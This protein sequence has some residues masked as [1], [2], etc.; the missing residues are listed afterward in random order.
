MITVKIT[1]Y[2]IEKNKRYK[3][4][5]LIEKDYNSL[6]VDNNFRVKL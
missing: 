6:L 5:K 4:Y 1:W 2:I 3:D